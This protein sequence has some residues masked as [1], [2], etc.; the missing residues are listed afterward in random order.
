[1]TLMVFLHQQIVEGCQFL[2]ATH[3][4]MLMA[5]P[6]AQILSLDQNPIRQ[7]EWEDVKHVKMMKRFFQDPKNYLRRLFES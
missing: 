7:L 4:P 6:G 3:S 5:F 2:I 1:M